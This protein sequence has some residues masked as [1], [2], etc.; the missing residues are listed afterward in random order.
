MMSCEMKRMLMGKGFWLTVF[1]AVI[2]ILMGATYPFATFGQAA[3][4]GSAM[5]SMGQSAV[6]ET[7]KILAAGSFL[8]MEK[9]ALLSK[10]VSFLLPVAAVLPWSSS[11]L[12]ESKNGFLKSMLPRIGRKNYTENKVLVVALAGFSVW[13]VAAI[14]VLGIYFIGFFPMEEKGTLTW[15]S[16]RELLEISVRQGLMGA[17]LSTLGGISAVL[18]GSGYMAFG[19]PFVGYYFCMILHERYFSEALWLYPVEWISGTAQWGENG[20]GLWLFLLLF[21]CMAMM[22][23]GGILYEKIKEF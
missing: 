18:T 21:L 19:L 6:P 4:A 2:G 22:I 13:I 1:L 11:F 15:E 16:F 12:D 8:R 14:L 5:T 17:V 23:H 7:E 20:L 9:D 3:D 10:T